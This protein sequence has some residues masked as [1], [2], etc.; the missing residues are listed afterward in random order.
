MTSPSRRARGRGPFAPSLRIAR[1][2]LA[3]TPPAIDRMAVVTTTARN[4]DIIRRSWAA[5][6]ERDMDRA[7]AAHVWT[8]RDGKV[9][10]IR[11]LQRH[12]GGPPGG[13]TG[14]TAHWRVMSEA[15]PIT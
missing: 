3:P 9:V 12:R 2:Y 10:Y 8:V 13:G 1:D 11:Q 7:A 4:E 5:W 6:M 14:S 15:V